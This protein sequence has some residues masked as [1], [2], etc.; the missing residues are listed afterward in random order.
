MST[1]YINSAQEQNQMFKNLTFSVNTTERVS[2]L[3]CSVLQLRKGQYPKYGNDK[4][5]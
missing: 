1:F 4:G 5:K 2:F 3:L